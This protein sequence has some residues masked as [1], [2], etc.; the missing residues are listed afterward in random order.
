MQTID[1]NELLQKMQLDIAS[2]QNNKIPMLE[3]DQKIFGKTFAE[4]LNQVNQLQNNAHE[5]SHRFE[6]GDETVEI[7][8]LMIALQK[9]NISLQ[10]TT[11]VRN[12]LVA[13][14]QEI[15]NMQI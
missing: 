6:L 4:A 14:Y 15:M 5:I 12:R 2:I 8:D 9:A 10:A 7:S 11:Q 1:S 13:A 3:S